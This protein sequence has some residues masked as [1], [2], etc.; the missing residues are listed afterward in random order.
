MTATVSAIN[1]CNAVIRAQNTE[2]TLIDISGEMNT[3]DLTLNQNVGRGI[4]PF[5][6]TFPVRLVC[7]KDATIALN[8]IYST[9]QAEAMQWLKDWYFNHGEDTRRVQVFVPDEEAGSDRY[10]FDCKLENFRIPG[11]TGN[12]D[13]ILVPVS[14]VP[15]GEF[16][17]SFVAS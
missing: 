3:F 8:I 10:Q 13:P 6:A 4:R 15:T 11:D 12:A 2:G 5:G 17:W 16:T 14:L 9:S 1:A 7:G